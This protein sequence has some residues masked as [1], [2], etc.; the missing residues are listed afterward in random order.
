M[1]ARHLLYI[2][3]STATI[4]LSLIAICSAQ[5][6]ASWDEAKSK[7]EFRAKPGSLL[8]SYIN[9]LASKYGSQQVG[10]HIWWLA[11]N[12]KWLKSPATE[13]DRV[14]ARAKQDAAA[15]HE[16]FHRRERSSNREQGE[17]TVKTQGKGTWQNYCVLA[18]LYVEDDQFA[19]AVS[20]E[21]KQTRIVLKE[22]KAFIES[23]NAELA[24]L[25]PKTLQALS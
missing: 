18:L 2:A 14:A 19:L 13:L 12:D 25:I 9:V 17:V 15:L 10:S 11:E 3:L 1:N 20:K 4:A 6:S 21:D 16:L 5:E 24:P 23:H 8:D 22:V 7:I